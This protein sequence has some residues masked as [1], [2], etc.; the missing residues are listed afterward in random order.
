MHISNEVDNTIKDIT[1]DNFK[2]GPENIMFVDGL[3]LNI[4]ASKNPSGG[5]IYSINGVDNTNGR[6]FSLPSIVSP[7]QIKLYV[8]NYLDVRNSGKLK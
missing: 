5:F 4:K 2:S 7:D 6:N 8:K 3:R 1:Q